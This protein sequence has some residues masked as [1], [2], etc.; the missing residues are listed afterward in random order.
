M[1][2][3]V[4]VPLSVY[5]AHDIGR[6]G[7]VPLRS[8]GPTSRPPPTLRGTVA[9]AL[10]QGVNAVSEIVIDGSSEGAVADAMKVG[11]AATTRD[12]IVRISA[13]NFEGK[14]GPFHF[15]LRGL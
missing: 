5:P 13:G 7:D 12:G 3:V 2:K 11:T 14:L 1:W 9:Y 8:Y 4:P 15:H 6:T 10:P